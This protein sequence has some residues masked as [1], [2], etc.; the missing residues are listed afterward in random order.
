MA[1]ES[2]LPTFSQTKPNFVVDGMLK[3]LIRWLRFLGFHSLSIT[4]WNEILEKLTNEANFIFITGSERNFNKYQDMKV[5]TILIKSNDIA[6]QLSELNSI[7][8]IYKQ[9]EPLTLCSECNVE[10]EMVNKESILSQI[11]EAISKTH[12]HFWQCPKCNRIYWE[13]GHIGRLKAKLR[14]MG[15]PIQN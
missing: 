13:G 11:P 8:N 3:G 15:I 14:Q 5:E 10:I 7:L 6:S 2:P 1:N 9:M 12:K 4:Q